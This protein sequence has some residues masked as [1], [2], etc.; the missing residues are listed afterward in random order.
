MILIRRS[1]I[2]RGGGFDEQMED[3]DERDEA[4]VLAAL[5]GA[6]EVAS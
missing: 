2:Y 1:W 3:W 6:A 5:R 4:E